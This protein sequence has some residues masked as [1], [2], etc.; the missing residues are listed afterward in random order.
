MSAPP[1][2]S[3][4]LNHPASSAALIRLSRPP[5]GV[6]SPVGTC[7]SFPVPSPAYADV[8]IAVYFCV[9]LSD[10]RFVPCDSSAFGS[11]AIALGF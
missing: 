8:G 10:S 6:P 2:L 5:S 7:I 1:S 4:S 3:E 11:N 9:S